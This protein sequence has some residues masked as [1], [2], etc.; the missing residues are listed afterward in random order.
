MSRSAFLCTGL[1][2]NFKHIYFCSKNVGWNNV[3]ATINKFVLHSAGIGKSHSEKSRDTE[4][5]LY[6]PEEVQFSVFVQSELT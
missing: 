2:C 3:K 5:S 6:F 1:T 4:L